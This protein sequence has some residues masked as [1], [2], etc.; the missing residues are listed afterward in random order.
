M[1]PVCKAQVIHDAYRGPV[2]C[3]VKEVGGDP[4][5]PDPR[6]HPLTIM[7]PCNLVEPNP[8]S[9]DMRGARKR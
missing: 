9:D 7:R 4:E 3:E 8:L 5:H 2:L 1:C 6:R